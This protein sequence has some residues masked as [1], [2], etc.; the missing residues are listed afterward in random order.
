MFKALSITTD[1]YSEFLRQAMKQ[2]Y[3]VTALVKV[4]VVGPAGVGK[5]CLLY[6]LLSKDPLE[7][8]TSTGCAE[9]AIQV[10]RI[11]QESGDWTEISPKEFQEIIAEAIPVLYKEL[12]AKG[13][14]MNNLEE[15]LSE[16]V[17]ERAEE[18]DSV[19]ETTAE[20]GDAAA[21]EVEGVEQRTVED[22][23]EDVQEREVR[24]ETFNDQPTAATEESDVADSNVIK[25]LT[26]LISSA[27]KSRRL[28]D[29]Q[30]IYM[31]D[32]GGQ[33]TGL[34]E[35]PLPTLPPM[36]SG[37]KLNQQAKFQVH[38]LPTLPLKETGLQLNQ[39]AVHHLP[40]LPLKESGL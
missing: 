33:E 13:G 11:G 4:L 30:M 28:L 24:D 34:W 38:P 29:M 19:V 15:L 31:T 23:V 27:K 12:T 21:G 40:T 10:I 35:F 16:A 3:V 17:G 22:G 39:E 36:K 25:K 8:R 20:G 1:D 32:S 37:L 9:R 5:T 2:G 14:R 26:R 6:L 18:N 7:L